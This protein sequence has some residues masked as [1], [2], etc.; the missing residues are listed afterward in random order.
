MADEKHESDNTAKAD[1]S[2]VIDPLTKKVDQL[3][4]SDP[5]VD[6]SA[7]TGDA[8]GDVDTFAKKLSKLTTSD[9]IVLLALK[10]GQAQS[11]LASLATDIA[12]L[13]SS[14]PTVDVKL[15][16]YA[17]TSQQLDDLETKIKAVG[18]TDPDA[19]ANLEKARTRLQGLGEEASKTQGAVHSMAG[20]AIG[21]F[22]ATATGIGPLGEALGQLTEMAT[23]GESSLRELAVAGLGLGAISG[24]MFLVNG[25]ISTFQ[26]SAAEAAKIKTFNVENAKIYTEAVRTNVDLVEHY[27][28]AAEKA[29]KVEVAPNLKEQQA[30]L[31]AM[32][33][34]ADKLKDNQGLIYFTKGI[35]DIST[36]LVDAGVNAADFYAATA[37]GGPALDAFNTKVLASNATAKEQYAILAAAKYQVDQYATGAADAA[38]DQA[39]F[40]KKTDEA[41]DAVR[42]STA[43][44]T[45]AGD[46]LTKW[47]DDTG[48]AI[49]GM[50]GYHDALANT[51]WGATALAG[52][53]T[54]MGNYTDTHFALTNILAT[55][56]GALDGLTAP[57]KE[58]GKTFDVTTDAGRAN[59][60][61]LQDVAHAMDT[62]LAAAYTDAHGNMDT[63]KSKANEISTKT[64][65]RL[66][67]ELGLS[68][69]Q[70]ADLAK[71]LG[72]LPEDIETR[73]KLSGDEEA[74]GK[75]QL[76]QTA[77]DNLPDDVQ[78]TVTQQIITG[79]YQGALATVNNYYSNHPATIPTKIE[80]PDPKD[81]NAV[82]AS[83]RAFF[84][85]NPV[86][87]KTS[88]SATTASAAPTTIVNNYG[89][90]AGVPSLAAA[91][92]PARWA[93]I[94]GRR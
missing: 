31:D 45:A 30:A 56:E 75:I 24:A 6:V 43:A 69:S 92:A 32:G 42:R 90:A 88:A 91:A 2:K 7:D 25:L 52:A 60:Q 33:T 72:L 73:Y 84:N 47:A 34:T 51:D 28:E 13:D 77:I 8:V 12:T 80:P 3:E 85:F 67:K 46:A 18:D 93:R 50:Q 22:A 57:V 87:V 61:A 65:T 38:Q 89:T 9:Q 27:R 66:Q 53:E 86:T 76:L 83:L 44:A 37:A 58:N 64:L 59:E 40:G 78:T 4:K 71:Q 15:S 10:A 39:L 70:T 49:T 1:A 48:R 5:T 79:D 20:N 62:E 16:Q 94:N 19:G 26:K 74:Q 36:D 54:A 23:G 81:T 11:E 82:L 35:Q 17:E 41:T 68:D 55:T 14:D 29:G 21:D 63:F